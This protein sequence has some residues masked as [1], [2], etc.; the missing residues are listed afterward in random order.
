MKIVKRRWDRE[1]L[2]EIGMLLFA[3]GLATGLGALLIGR[4]T[5]STRHDARRVENPPTAGS[6]PSER[7][8]NVLNNAAR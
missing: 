8:Q 2:L 5:G 6:V 3:G 1:A 7:H 4:V